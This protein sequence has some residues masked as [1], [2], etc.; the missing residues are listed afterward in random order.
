MVVDRPVPSGQTS[1]TGLRTPG[2]RLISA[3]DMKDLLGRKPEPKWEFVLLG[4]RFF[5]REPDG[6]WW[7]YAA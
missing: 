6:S 7:E 3:A 4:D 5:H 1:D 2:G